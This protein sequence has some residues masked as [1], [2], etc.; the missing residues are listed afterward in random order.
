MPHRALVT[1]ARESLGT[2]DSQCSLPVAAC[3]IARR[4]RV[5]VGRSEWSVG[6]ASTLRKRHRAQRELLAALV[7]PSSWCSTVGFGANSA[8]AAAADPAAEHTLLGV[9][10]CIALA[11]LMQQLSLDGDRKGAAA[12]LVVTACGYHRYHTTGA[13]QI[14]AT[15]R[16]AEFFRALTCALSTRGARAQLLMRSC[17]MS[18]I[19][20]NS[21]RGT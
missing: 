4:A 1:G 17:S 2:R 8:T 9:G 3:R 16:L 12:D 13:R 18:L 15:V 21:Q 14:M 7:N 11:A 10:D 6:V 5:R 19:D 20:Y